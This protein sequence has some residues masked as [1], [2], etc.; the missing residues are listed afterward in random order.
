MNLARSTAL[1]CLLMGAT[2]ASAADVTECA[3]MLEADEARLACYDRI[4]LAE[5]KRLMLANPSEKPKVEVSVQP[6]AA[7]VPKPSAP[8]PTISF[9]ARSFKRIDPADVKNTPDKWVGRDIEFASVR[10]YWVADDDL[11]VLTTDGM[12]LFGRAPLGDPA[13]VAYLREN[14][15]TSKEADSNKC[16]VRVRFNYTEHRTDTPGGMFKRTILIAPQ[17][18][19]ARIGKPKR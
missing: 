14:C 16:R 13:D 1:A 3:T 10:V 19:F 6:I 7:A 9:S 11:R 15:E 4:V 17:V 2:A 18:E 12:T 5:M 8:P